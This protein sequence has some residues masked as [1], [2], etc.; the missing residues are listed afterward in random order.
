MG[1]YLLLLF[2]TIII[3]KELIIVFLRL[4]NWIFFHWF[5][6]FLE[7]KLKNFEYNLQEN[8]SSTMTVKSLQG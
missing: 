8:I 1:I 2:I 4:Y 3:I 5:D 6:Y 7:K